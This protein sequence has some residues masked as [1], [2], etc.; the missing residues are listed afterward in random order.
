MHQTQYLL[1][2]LLHHRPIMLVRLHADVLSREDNHPNPLK[3][4]LPKKKAAVAVLEP[5]G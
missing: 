3:E 2:L 4:S 1:I 5:V